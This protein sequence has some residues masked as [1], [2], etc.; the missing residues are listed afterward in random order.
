MNAMIEFGFGAIIIYLEKDSMM[1]SYARWDDIINKMPE[2]SSRLSFPW[3]RRIDFLVILPEYEHF[4]YIQ[5]IISDAMI[6]IY[7][8]IGYDSD[9]FNTLEYNDGFRSLV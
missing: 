4:V 7:L 1:M 8:T 3:I 5:S 2:L 6:F 9:R